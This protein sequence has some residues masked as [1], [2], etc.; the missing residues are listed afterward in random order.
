MRVAVV[1]LV[2]LCGAAAFADDLQRANELAWAKHFAEAE[3]L[4]RTLPPS[5]EVTLALARVVMWQGRYREAIA[6]FD[7]VDGV[8][9]IEGRAT[10]EYWS[11]DLRRAAR[12]FRRVLALAPDRAFARTSLA[13]IESLAS[14]SQRMSFFG[15][16]DDQPLDA[17]RGELAATFFSD[18]LTRWTI[19]AGGYALDAGRIGDANGELV[20]VEN[21]T[22]AG[23][24]TFGGSIG[25][26]AF[27]DGA[28]R[29]IGSISVRRRQLELRVD[30]REE[31]A[32][33]TA[34]RTHASST[35][36]TLRWNHE[37]NWIAAA[38]VSHRQYFDDNR[39]RS[40]LAYAVY[41]WHR[42][43]W[44]LWTGGSATWRDTDESRFRITATSSTLEQNFF[45]YA[46]RGEYDPYWTPDDLREARAVVALERT[47]ARGT[48]KIQ[49]DAGIAHDRGRAFGPDAGPGPFPAN[50]FTFAFDRDYH[51]WRAGISAAF[52]IAPQLRIETGVE[53]SV[54]VDYRA[55]SFYAA[56]VRRR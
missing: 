3:A 7:R 43:A 9:A 52:D 44:T 40:V 46:Y 36:T 56:L 22:V 32:S 12:D 16:H 26:L 55:T 29:P 14:P 18:P 19:V 39:A 28:R 1:L 17:I 37:R 35:T 21:Q 51:P 6:L 49:G 41:P 10:A 53:R 27:P 50:P 8:D 13:E 47:F 20:R 4:Y 38:E 5:R 15:T 54:T 42:D 31:F 48:F 11:G 24:W 2:M 23:A 45:R 33:A 30:R 25:V 34:L